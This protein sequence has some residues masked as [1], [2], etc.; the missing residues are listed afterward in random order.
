MKQEALDDLEGLEDL[1]DP[2]ALSD[3]AERFGLPN[4]VGPDGRVDPAAL[5]ALSQ[6]L[7]ERLLGGPA[8]NGPGKGANGAG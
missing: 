6:Q 5:E 1:A 8:A 4:P 7:G 2:Q 3:M